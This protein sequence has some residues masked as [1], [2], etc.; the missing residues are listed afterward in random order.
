ML[1]RRNYPER[2]VVSSLAALISAL[3]NNSNVIVAGGDIA[4]P[5][6]T[7]TRKIVQLPRAHQRRRAAEEFAHREQERQQQQQTT[8]RALVS[9]GGD[10]SNILEHDLRPLPRFIQMMNR[11]I[12]SQ[13]A[14]DIEEDATSSAGGGKTKT[15]NNNNN[16]NDRSNSV[17]NAAEDIVAEFRSTFP[18]AKLENGSGA[19]ESPTSSVKP[20]TAYCGATADVIPLS[21]IVLRAAADINDIDTARFLFALVLREFGASD[22]AASV[23]LSFFRLYLI[24]LSRND[25]TTHQEVNSLVNLISSNNSSRSTNCSTKRGSDSSPSPP[26]QRSG[27]IQLCLLEIAMRS[28]HSVPVAAVEAAIRAT[29]EGVA[30]GDDDPAEQRMKLKDCYTCALTAH[31]DVAVATLLLQ[32]WTN[33]S[34]MKEFVAELPLVTRF[35]R[36]AAG[37]AAASAALCAQLLALLCGLAKSAAAAA[38]VASSEKAS[39]S[40]PSASVSSE[41]EGKGRVKQSESAIVGQQQQQLQSSVA[42]LTADE[43]TG[44]ALA[45]V[46]RLRTFFSCISKA[47]RGQE[48]APFAAIEHMA[49]CTLLVCEEPWVNINNSSNSDINSV[50]DAQSSSS[51]SSAPAEIV[52][53]TLLS[54][55]GLLR[56]VAFLRQRQFSALFDKL[57]KIQSDNFPLHT[58]VPPA[59]L[60]RLSFPE[61][62]DGNS[63]PFFL[64]SVLPL[65]REVGGD[66]RTRSAAAARELLAGEVSFPVADLP[67]MSLVLDSARSGAEGIVSAWLEFSAKDG[68]KAL[69]RLHPVFCAVL[70]VAAASSA[71]PRAL[72]HVF[73]PVLQEYI[74]VDPAASVMKT[75][76]RMALFELAATMLHRSRLHSSVTVTSSEALKEALDT[77]AIDVAEIQNSSGSTSTKSGATGRVS[78]SF[79]STLEATLRSHDIHDDAWKTKQ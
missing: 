51:L 61:D 67:P 11:K 23:P 74:V 47:V 13:D 20:L 14:D 69:E 65:R 25:T 12:A 6:Q 43:E 9:V 3:R 22:L 44:A 75:D 18:T 55:L 42:S 79:I 70:L 68:N 60:F 5:L 16:N 40:S 49:R 34:E 36:H 10:D 7:P 15:S 54:F 38:S 50:S 26:V 8:P 28:G 37:N 30:R 53:S 66:E 59:S 29:R 1:R 41:P 64:Q 76:E 39:S 57:H 73:V 19:E 46:L 78:S 77:L 33:V 52:R 27:V 62:S 45:S 2:Q 24:A 63:C 4:I 71:S 56:I 17:E 48:W 21:L 72:S 58:A 35:V 31:P 32:E